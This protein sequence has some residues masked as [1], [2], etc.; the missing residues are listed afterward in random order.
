MSTRFPFPFP[1]PERLPPA[2]ALADVLQLRGGGGWLTPPLRP[3]CRGGPD[4]VLGAA[5]TVRMAAGPGEH[6]LAPLRAL[7]GEDLPGRVVLVAGADCAE[8]AVW[9]EILTAAAVA[10]GAVGALVE[11]RVRDVAALARLP[12]PV[13]A[14]GEATAG[15]GTEVHVAEIGG[16]VTI[17]GVT[18]A[19]GDPVLLDDGG[20]VALDPAAAGGLLADAAAYHRAEESVLAAA[21]S[22]LRLPLAYAPKA[23]TVAEIRRREG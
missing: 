9:G 16:P 19:D 15:P 6:G 22:G 20:A 12:L 10:R 7:L 23:R 8:G 21:V 18:V 13:W 5:R 1:L 4:P 17:G 11:G 14:L 2:T 3:F